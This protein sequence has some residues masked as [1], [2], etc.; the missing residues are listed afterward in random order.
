[1]TSYPVTVGETPASRK[2]GPGRVRRRTLIAALAGMTAPAWAVEPPALATAAS[3]PSRPALPPLPP[4]ET[5][6]F[7]VSIGDYHEGARLAEVSYRLD[8]GDGVYRIDT[9]AQATGVVALVYS[10]QLTQTSE[11]VVGP[12]GLV[13]E[14]YVEKRGR[15]PERTLRFDRSRGRMIGNGDPPE[16]ALPV[17]TQDRLSL[18]YQLGLIARA[19]RRAT[20]AGYHLSLPL[21]SMKRIE[22]ASIKCGGE[23]VLRVRGEHFRT[24]KY[25]IRNERHADDRIDIWLGP[26]QFML[27]VRIRFE[28]GDGRVIDQ[29]LAPRRS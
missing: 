19:D 20:K 27:P 17:G 22:M 10:G 13:P 12:D 16:V 29:V 1:M 5:R 7:D 15:R 6:R 2:A 8:H 26:D 24:V 3:L 14:R 28:E 23:T 11:G 25:E 4:P 18:G 21:A 9:A